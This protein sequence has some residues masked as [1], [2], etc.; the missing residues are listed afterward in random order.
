V[1]NKHNIY[2]LFGRA[3]I[4]L[5]E[6]GIK[7]CMRLASTIHKINYVS[8]PDSSSIMMIDEE[9]EGAHLLPGGSLNCSSYSIRQRIQSSLAI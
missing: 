1:Y 6:N 2:L 4:L 5:L 3:K 9:K 7:K 8:T